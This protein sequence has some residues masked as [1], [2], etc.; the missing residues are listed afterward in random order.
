MLRSQGHHW[1]RRVSVVYRWGRVAAERWGE[2]VSTDEDCRGQRHWMG[3]W[4]LLERGVRPFADLQLLHIVD[5]FAVA[6]EPRVVLEENGLG[7]LEARRREKQQGEQIQRE[8]VDRMDQACHEEEVVVVVVGSD[9]E[10]VDAVVVH[11]GRVLGGQE[12]RGDR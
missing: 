11:M 3:G 5:S 12:D 9:G 8:Q 7:T 4:R 6:A 1:T 10:V 2:F